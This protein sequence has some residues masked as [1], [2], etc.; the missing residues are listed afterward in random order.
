MEPAVDEMSR[1]RQPESSDA[2]LPGCA[3][4]LAAELAG[5][6]GPRPIDT[7]PI[8]TRPIDTRPIDTRPIE[9]WTCDKRT[10]DTRPTDV[11]RA[12]TDPRASDWTSAN[13][14]MSSQQASP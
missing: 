7:R 1:T 3:T 5:W 12:D 9:T 2:G 11:G 13:R 6:S 8:D 10:I 4:D 14:P